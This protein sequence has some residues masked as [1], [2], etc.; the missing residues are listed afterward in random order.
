MRSP[1]D[2]IADEIR[3]L[4]AE[5]VKNC[6]GQISNQYGTLLT[7]SLDKLVDKV[8]R[9]YDAS[10]ILESTADLFNLQISRMYGQ[11]EAFK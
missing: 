10:E 9:A 4:E 1:S 3:G 7:R 6:K 8:K 11:F 5:L 2:V